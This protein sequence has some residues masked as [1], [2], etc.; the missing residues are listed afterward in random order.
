MYVSYIFIYN[1][2]GLAKDCWLRLF[3]PAGPQVWPVTVTS[4]RSFRSLSS[5]VM[6]ALPGKKQALQS[7]LAWLVAVP[8]ACS[9]CKATGNIHFIKIQTWNLGQIAVQQRQNF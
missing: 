7:L 9:K 4:L 5:S 2:L 3:S 1:E 6:P 8:S